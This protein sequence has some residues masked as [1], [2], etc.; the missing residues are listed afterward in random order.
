MLNF[1]CARPVSFRFAVEQAI[2]PDWAL[3]LQRFAPPSNTVS[4]SKKRSLQCLWIHSPTPSWPKFY[5]AHHGLPACR[6]KTSPLV[7]SSTLGSMAMGLR[8][9]LWLTLALGARWVRLRLARCMDRPT[10]AVRSC[11]ATAS[12][13]LILSKKCQK[14]TPHESCTT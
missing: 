1:L 6:R 8:W 2:V 5:F 12:H 9:D 11:D 3:R 14:S 7:S 13:H 10:C 4:V